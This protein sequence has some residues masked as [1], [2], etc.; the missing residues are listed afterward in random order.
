M[1]SS[2]WTYR[3]KNAHS[4]MISL[5]KNTCMPSP[6][7][8]AQT[9]HA[10]RYTARPAIKPYRQC[11]ERLWCQ[12][13][14]MLRLRWK[15]GGEE[16]NRDPWPIYRDQTQLYVVE[17]LRNRPSWFTWNR[18]N[19]SYSSWNII[20][21]FH[22]QSH[23]PQPTASQNCFLRLPCHNLQVPAWAN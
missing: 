9:F 8:G 7:S 12:R 10:L 18:R 13:C 21:Y 23:P 16:F 3:I 6:A 14:S 5:L 22:Q 1:L 4:K 15:A 19:L 17:L 20:S 2:A 11:F